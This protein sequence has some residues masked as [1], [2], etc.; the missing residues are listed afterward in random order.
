M[1]YIALDKNENKID[2]KKPMFVKISRDIDA[3]C[4]ALYAIF[5]AISNINELKSIEVFDSEH[6]VFSGIIDEQALECSNNG[7]FIKISA[8]NMAA[9]LIDNEAIPQNYERASL[10]VI[11][12]RHIKPYGFTDFIGNEEPFADKFIVYKGMSEWDVLYSFCYKFLR[13]HPRVVNNT[14]IDA[15][16]IYQSSNKINIDSRSSIKYKS[17][18]YLIKRYKRISEVFI[19]TKNNA[20]Y[21]VRAYD[22][23]AIE[24]GIS[25]KRY[26]NAF[27]DSRTPCSFGEDMIQD[28]KFSSNIVKAKCIGNVHVSIGDYADISDPIIGNMQDLIVQKIIYSLQ[29]SGEFTE[30]YMHRSE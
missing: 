2:L 6:L 7:C 22:K 5:P 3:P 16:G 23:S 18:N 10:K 21:D 1:R 24:D 19:R 17:I 29:D 13:T 25:R 15:S 28:A 20:S 8:R 9:L 27:N 4:D 12:D 30:I 14:V 26:L 11:F